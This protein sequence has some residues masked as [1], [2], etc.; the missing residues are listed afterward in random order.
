MS[1]EAGKTIPVGI[2]GLGRAGW[3]IHVRTLDDLTDLYRVAA[4]CDIDPA[5]RDE[6]RD[7]LGCR[8]Y[9]QFEEMLADPEIELVTVAPPSYL[10]AEMSIAALKAGKNVL[11]EKPFATN[12]KDAEKMIATAKQTGRVLTCHQNSRYT[13]DFLKVRE[14]LASGK[15][16][17]VFFIRMA[18]QSFSRRWDWQT[19]QEFGGGMLNNNGT[20][21]VDQALLLMGVAEPQVFCRMES[22]PLISGD[23]E[24]HVKVILQAPDAPMIDVEITTASAY[25]QEPWLVM[26][27]LGGL[28][29]SRKELRWKYLDPNSLPPRPVDTQPTP[30]RSY[31]REKLEWIEESWDGSQVNAPSGT[32][33]LYRELYATLREGAPLTVSIESLARQSRVLQQCRDQSPVSKLTE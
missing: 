29:G 17:R 24:D 13:P 9:A 8:T 5:R 7:K 21:I 3:D 22:T 26:G 15:L 32:H 28:T 23:A 6:A 20:H 2:V 16:G 11:V 4:V 30:D 12:L 19:L 31:N 14:I 1:A 10:H 33:Q 27:T 25:S 18:W